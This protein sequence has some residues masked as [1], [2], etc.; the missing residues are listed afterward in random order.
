MSKAILKAS[1]C[2]IALIVAP[3]SAFAG[4]TQSESSTGVDTAK[5]SKHADNGSGEAIEEVVVT[6]QKR[7]EFAQKIPI[8][9]AVVTGE[10]IAQKADTTLESVLTSVPSVDVQGISQGAQVYIRGVGSSIDP[11]FADSSTALMVDGVYNGRTEALQA[12][13][14]D[15][16]RIEV[17]RGPQGTLYGR[18]ATG[19]LINVITASP[20]FNRFSGY[21][22]AQAGDYDLGRIEAAVNVPLS[23]NLAIRLAGYK[24]KRSGY[25]DDGSD[26]SDSYGIR[27][28][29]LYAPTDWLS[30]LLKVDYYHEQ[31]K[32]QN[33]VPVP[34]SAGHLTVPPFLFFNPDGSERFPNGWIQPHQGDPWSN[35]AVH[36]PGVVRRQSLTY[37]A[38][39]DADLGFAT[40]TV[41]PAYTRSAT[42]VLSSYL[43]G[44]L[45]PF[46]ATYD[47]SGY[48]GQGIVT[49]YKSVEA[50][51]K[52]NGTG[53]LQYVVGFYYLNTS[54][55]TN[56]A[57]PQPDIDPFTGAAVTFSQAFQP[58]STTAGFGEATYAIT[59]QLRLT[60]GFRYSV[61]E[62]NQ[63]YDITVNGTDTGAQ[64]FKTTQESTQYKIGA[65][66]DVAPESMLYAH[67]ATGFKQGGMSATI[68]ANPFLPEHLTAYEIGSKNR[69]FDD[70]LQLNAAAFY[71]DYQN[72]QYY[73]F[74]FLPIGSTGAGDNFFL[75]RN[76]GATH[77]DGAEVE[78]EAIPWSN[79][80]LNA[81]LT[82]L[83]A[84][85][86][87]AVMPNNPFVNQGNFELKG[88]PIQEAPDWAVNLGFEQGFYIGNN[89]L[90]LGVNS[91]ISAGYYASPE[92][93][94]PGAWQPAF[95]RTDLNARYEM[96][97]GQYFISV[98]LKNLENQAQTTYVYPGY[99]RLVTAPRTIV[100][101]IGANF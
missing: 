41:L 47:T 69:F 58:G 27:G 45:T 93:Y 26:D 73:N 57:S 90:F 62:N 25:I 17:L 87:E 21:V 35:D 48:G 92:Q 40:L 20:T 84:K 64:S 70:K 31:G 74:V 37:A 65:E 14:Y 1:V 36:V 96:N 32:G 71:Y 67:V 4:T 94:L 13:A 59:P 55:G 12:V 2:A 16:Q 63:A 19:G 72:Y 18:N 34:G 81:S 33:T 5:P 43:F 24:E 53:P 68:P 101:S 11:G 56:G 46:G 86:G 54:P 99:R 28:K 39:I 9:I 76:S 3:M 61:D 80:K 83:D 7:Q 44:S 10:E 85:Y 100:A 82:Y 66:Y 79:A 30:V 29:I 23:S 50:R 51:L 49:M 8:S 89:M 78:M 42:Y 15:I 91:H 38:Q 97:D 77:I 75:I 88:R 60:G 52:S 22:R 98:N 95:T 6:A